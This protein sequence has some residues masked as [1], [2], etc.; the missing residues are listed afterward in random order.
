MIRR[1]LTY[2]KLQ[3]SKEDGKCG[4]FGCMQEDEWV[5]RHGLA[6]LP[7]SDVKCLSYS[8]H[9]THSPSLHHNPS[10]LGPRELILWERKCGHWAMA[11]PFPSHH[12]HWSCGS[13]N[14]ILTKNITTLQIICHSKR[15]R[16]WKMFWVFVIFV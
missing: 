2:W 13:E 8:Y 7:I 11:T 12:F 4:S 9:K 14:L 5:D 6:P 10:S 16:P 3:E 15:F 1:D